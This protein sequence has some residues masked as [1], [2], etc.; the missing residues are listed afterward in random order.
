MFPVS[1]P[2]KFE[3][4]GFVGEKTRR[5]QKK[6]QSKDKNQQQTQPPS[7]TKSR[8]QTQAI[9]VGGKPSHHNLIPALTPCYSAKGKMKVLNSQPQV[10]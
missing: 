6:C 1:R 9:A 7:D 8:N 2:I 4:L 10:A 3:I 5:P